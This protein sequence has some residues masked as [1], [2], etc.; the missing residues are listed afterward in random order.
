[1]PLTKQE[2]D[3]MTSHLAANL[4]SMMVARKIV[5]FAARGKLAP[6]LKLFRETLEEVEET[7]FEK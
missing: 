3:S 2:K 7:D 4:C 6:V 5:M 1:M